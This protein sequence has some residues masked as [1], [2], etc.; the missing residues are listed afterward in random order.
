MAR[1]G[2]TFRFVKSETRIILFY[3]KVEKYDIC[4]GVNTFIFG[5]IFGGKIFWRA[6]LINKNVS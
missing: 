5:D 6:I 4:L 2:E 1:N 3:E